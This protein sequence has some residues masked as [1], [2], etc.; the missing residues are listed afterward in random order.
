MLL[1]LENKKILRSSCRD[2]PC[3]RRSPVSELP[4]CSLQAFPVSVT[5]P[6]HQKKKARANSSQTR[7][8]DSEIHS[9]VCGI[10]SDPT[11]PRPSSTTFWGGRDE[12]IRKERKEWK[13]SHTVFT[14]CGF[15]DT[16]FVSKAVTKKKKKNKKRVAS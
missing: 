4:Y 1:R 11:H 2:A 16:S 12:G 3:N 14:P 5:S 9:V 8:Q 10:R 13:L 7:E 15:P 6:P